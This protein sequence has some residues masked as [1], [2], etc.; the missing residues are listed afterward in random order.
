MAAREPGE[1][2]I[3]NSTNMEGELTA[4]ATSI[5][6]RLFIAG[7]GGIKAYNAHSLPE[8]EYLGETEDPTAARELLALGGYLL[9]F[10]EN[11]VGV[12]NI[13]TL[14]LRDHYP[15]GYVESALPLGDSM[16]LRTSENDY[17]VLDLSRE[18]PSISGR[19]EADYLPDHAALKSPSFL[20]LGHDGLL[21]VR[22]EGETEIRLYGLI[23]YK[24]DTE[25]LSY[26]LEEV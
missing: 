14:E 26:Y 13:E 8:F 3:I 21:T 23:Q 12:F 9:S 4:M 24:T 6:G 25:T 1:I 11:G 5:D 22:G 20:R 16:V 10:G 19:I 2:E 7:A 15:I 17:F 18:M